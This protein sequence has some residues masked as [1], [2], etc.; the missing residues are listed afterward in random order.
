MKIEET[1]IKISGLKN[2]YHFLHISDVHFA[3]ASEDDSIKAKEYAIA[4]TKQWSP[5][6]SSSWECWDLLEEYAKDKP[7]IEALVITGD[8]L[9]YYS[10]NCFARARER[11][12]DFPAKVYI[13]PGNHEVDDGVAKET[14]VKTYFHEYYDP[15]MCGNADFWVKDYEEFLLVG[16]NNGKREITEVQL[17]RLKEQMK[18]KVPMILVMHIPLESEAVLDAIKKRWGEDEDRY[19]IFEGKKDQSAISKEFA[20]LIKRPD[21]PVVA[22]LA[23]HIHA[24]CEGE[25]A[26]GKMQYT[27]APL[28]EKYIREITII[29]A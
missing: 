4:K 15:L 9:D 23:G 16:I 13:T 1:C 21:S 26:S 29:S 14:D 11:V 5:T 28:H 22:I 27:A 19:F 2:E 10:H 18:R 7:Q 3:H 20:E 6:G 24:A 12:E 17:D 25:F 8:F